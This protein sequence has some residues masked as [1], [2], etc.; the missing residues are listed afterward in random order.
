MIDQINKLIAINLFLL[1][2]SENDLLSLK[3]FKN[4]QGNQ[5]PGAKML[6]EIMEQK[7]LI[8]SVTENEFKYEL[9]EF[10]KQIAQN[11]GWLVYVAN[12]KKSKKHTEFDRFP[13][14]KTRKPSIELIIAGIIIIALSC[15]IVSCI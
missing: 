10:G 5:L 13:K 11:G 6:A 14:T 8:K 1:F 2:T 12:Q 3:D 7:Q 9:T 15:L 4:E